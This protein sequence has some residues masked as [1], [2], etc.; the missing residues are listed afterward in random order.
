MFKKLNIKNNKPI[1]LYA[2]TFREADL[3]QEK[4][5]LNIES[6]K[7]LKDYNILL[8]LHPLIRNK[9][10][11][12]LYKKNKNFINCC[13]YPDISDILCI[14]DI[15]IS[16][17]SSIIYEFSIL[18]KPIIFYAYDLED[19][20]KERGFYIEYPEDLPGKTVYNEKEL[21]T[22]LL[23]I[24]KESKEYNKKLKQFNKKFNYLNDGKVCERFT[25]LLKNG[26]I[27]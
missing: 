2:P 27:K 5:D 26:S 14:T 7:V 17:Y 13:H 12:N 1:I 4:V 15:L 23:N 6:L 19:Y 18:E 3:E 24:K 8:R 20:K 25:K 9:I 11:E 10:D 16:D 21:L 22:T